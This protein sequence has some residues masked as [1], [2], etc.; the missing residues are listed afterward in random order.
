MRL[1][2]LLLLSSAVGQATVCATG[3]TVPEMFARS[4]VVFVGEIERFAA[5]RDQEGDPEFQFRVRVIEPFKGAKPD[6]RL[7]ILVPYISSDLAVGKRQLWFL[8][9]QHRSLWIDAACSQTLRPRHLGSDLLFLRRLP[10]SATG[11]RLAGVL[12]QQV[13][14]P[15]AQRRVTLPLAGVRVTVRGANLTRDTLTNQDGAYEF[16]GLPP[17]NYRL[18]TPPLPG[19][20]SQGFF[21]YYPRRR[22]SPELIPVTATSTYE[23]N[24]T[25]VEEMSISGTVLDAAGR[26]A[27][28]VYVEVESVSPHPR[29]VWRQAR[30]GPDGRFRVE[31]LSVGQ[32]R[33]TARRPRQPSSAKLLS[34][35]SKQAVTGL[36]LRLP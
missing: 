18:D 19:L 17:G 34:I 24:A 2:L 4:K 12:Q 20:R 36:I 14:S 32:Y 25:F 1:F 35:A 27:E 15:Q 29:E 7:S 8:Q 21:G 3:A 26:P 6:D 31:E 13:H 16:S 33:I 11:N 22:E 30:T 9:Y 5:G 28:G 23:V 10:Q